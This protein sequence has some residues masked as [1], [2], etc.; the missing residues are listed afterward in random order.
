[1]ANLLENV[2]KRRFFPTM[3]LKDDLPI[4]QGQ[5]KDSQLIGLRKRI[6]SFSVKIQP[7]SSSASN[8]W[9]F[10]RSKSMP[11]LTGLTAAPLRRWWDRSWAWVLS[12]K[13]DFARD[14]EMNEEETAMLGCHGKGSWRHVF[15]K[16]RA[17]IRKLIGSGSSLPTTHKFRYDSFNYAQNF[18]DGKSGAE[19]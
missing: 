2:Q 4:S 3:P 14:L 15:F 8:A 9:A 10:T 19:Q 16:V 13:P 17:E 1:M 18:D 6:S 7:I 12:R 5:Q 11:S